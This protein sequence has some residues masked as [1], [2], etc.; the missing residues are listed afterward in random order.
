MRIS[1]FPIS[2]CRL[3]IFQGMQFKKRIHGI[4]A[5]EVIV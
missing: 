5:I 1:L 2:D 4:E 3:P